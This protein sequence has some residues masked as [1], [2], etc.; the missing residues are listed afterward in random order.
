[1]LISE[2][3]R[4]LEPG[5]Q[6]VETGYLRLENG[7][8]HVRVLTRMPRCKGKM[9]DWWFGYLDGTEKYQMWEPKSH[10]SLER[11]DKWKPNRYVGASHLVEERLG[12]IVIKVRIRF[13]DPSE[14]FDTSKFKDA[15]IGAVICGKAYK[16]DGAPDGTVI[17]LL[18]DTD[19]GCEMRSRFWLYG[20]PEMAGPGLMSHCLEEMGH[21][22][23]ILPAL[24]RQETQN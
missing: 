5:Y 14:F 8:L 2:V 12:D 4:L 20:A 1:M 6:S 15:R 23:D 21:L 13:H 16:P 10:I 11:D 7:D 9:V 17:H 19:Y 24:Y 18:R 22:A 3:N